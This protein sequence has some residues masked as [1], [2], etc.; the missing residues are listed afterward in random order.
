MIFLNPYFVYNYMLKI[1]SSD[2]KVKCNFAASISISRFKTRSGNFSSSRTSKYR[3]YS[4]NENTP[5]FYSKCG[6][7]C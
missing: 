6:R 2:S 7:D 5:S 1:E 4:T 3:L